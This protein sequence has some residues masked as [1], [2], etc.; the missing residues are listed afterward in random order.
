MKDLLNYQSCCIMCASQAV[1]CYWISTK[2]LDELGIAESFRPTGV[3]SN[4]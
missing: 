2:A 3:G 1:A 4:K